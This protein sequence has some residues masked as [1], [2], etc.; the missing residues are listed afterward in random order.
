MKSKPKQKELLFLTHL[1]PACAKIGPFAA[2]AIISLRLLWLLMGYWSS[3]RS[4]D[5][6]VFLFFFTWSFP[7]FLRSANVDPE[8]TVSVFGGGCRLLVGVRIARV[9]LRSPW[10]RQVPSPKTI[11]R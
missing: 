5:T 2:L 6:P 4:R 3:Q 8:N 10:L 1:T 9:G 11:G 7:S